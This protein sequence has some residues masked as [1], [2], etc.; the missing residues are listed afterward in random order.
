[1]W[2]LILAVVLPPLIFN[3]RQWRLD[4]DH[5]RGLAASRKPIPS[6]DLPDGRVPKV[7]FLVAAWNA[8]STLRACIEAIQHLRYP[9]LE[10]VLCAGG[11]DRTWKI[12]SEFNASDK[13]PRLILIAQQPGDG[14]QRSLER[15]LEKAT[16][17]IVYL[18][19]ADGCVTAEAF[20]RLIGPILGGDEQVVTNSPYTPYPGWI[21]NPFVVSQCASQL[22]TS[23]H[24]PEYSSGILGSNCAILRAALEQAGGFDADVPTGV[25]YHLGKRLLG[26]SRRVRYEVDASFPT[27][28]HTHMLPY[29]R[30][31]TRWMRNVAIYG[32]HFRAWREVI[33]CLA[34]SLTG[35]AMLVLP[36]LWLGLVFSPGVSPAIPRI[37][38]AVWAS[39]LLH[40]FLSRLR[41]VNIAARW[42]G[43]RFPR[44]MPALLPLFML[45]DFI[46]WTLPL[47]QYPSRALRE[48]W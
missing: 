29:L 47:I 7:S 30:Q 35:L 22:Y 20:A 45:I 31:Q 21:G 8:E 4:L 19:D 23:I 26:Q 28:F 16:G 36:C 44:R 12:A 33:S 46:A 39:A 42:L 40:A 34:A 14:K 17:S 6:L 1:M 43:V 10:I 13:D 18:L 5:I 9:G 32:I 15:C 41:Y 24:Q 3:L 48:R 38:A 25:D 11:T 37:I 27:G 2:M